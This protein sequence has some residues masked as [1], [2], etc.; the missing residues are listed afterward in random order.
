[1]V[2]IKEDFLRTSE[3]IESGDRVLVISHV[4]EKGCAH[5]L[6]LGT[7]EGLHPI[8]DEAVGCQAALCR[9]LGRDNPRITLDGGGTVWG[10]E[11][12]FG[13][14]EE[15]K[16]ILDM[17][18][19]QKRVDQDLNSLREAAQKF[20]VVKFFIPPRRQIEYVPVAVSNETFSKMRTLSALGLRLEGEPL[21]TGQT[22][23]A[24]S[25]EEEDEEIEIVNHSDK[26]P[27][28]VEKVVSEAY[29]RRSATFA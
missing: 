12:W 27:E 13:A 11:C 18:G 9:A 23:I 3:T 10:A 20:L 2:N 1:L 16:R 22:S 15:V 14:E 19:V 7:F 28:A 5:V 26:I 6:G 29:N 4:D 21:R 25:S 24:I 17:A 8:G